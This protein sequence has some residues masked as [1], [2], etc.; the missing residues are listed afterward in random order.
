MRTPLLKHLD[1][2]RLS[3]LLSISIPVLRKSPFFPH[4]RYPSVYHIPASCCGSCIS[5]ELSQQLAYPVAVLSL[6]IALSFSTI[7]ISKVSRAPSMNCFTIP[8]CLNARKFGSNLF[9][10]IANQEVPLYNLPVLLGEKKISLSCKSTKPQ[11]KLSSLYNG[12]PQTWHINLPS[13][14]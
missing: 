7:P 6:L 12:F 3:R 11:R 13:V 2:A 14:M 10:T 4:A 1:N 8:G 9:L 5:S